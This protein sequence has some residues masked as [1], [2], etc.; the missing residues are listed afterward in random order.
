[1]NFIINVNIRNK[2]NQK[3]YFNNELSDKFNLNIEYKVIN[4]DLDKPIYSM[5]IYLPLGVLHSELLKLLITVSCVH[6]DSDVTED[7]NWVKMR[8]EGNPSSEDI[9]LIAGNLVK[10]IDDYPID[11]NS[12]S[13]GYQGIM[14]ILLLA[15]ISYLLKM[16]SSFM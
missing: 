1:V 15:R 8:I 9:A 4:D 14:Q 16:K 6:V 13:E 3:E 11:R 7:K 10:E 12:F 5:T 2:Y